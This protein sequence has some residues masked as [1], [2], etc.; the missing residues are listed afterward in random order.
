[1]NWLVSLIGTGKKVTGK[2]KG[3]HKDTTPQSLH[4]A[5]MMDFSFC[6]WSPSLLVY[7][8]LYTLSPSPDMRPSGS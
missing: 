6:R 4:P 3:E 1:M 5:Q 2:S 7:I 8:S